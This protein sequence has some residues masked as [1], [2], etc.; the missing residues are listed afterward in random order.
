MS[1]QQYLDTRTKATLVQQLS[2]TCVINRGK[3]YL[4]CT[5]LCFTQNI[6]KTLFP[7]GDKYI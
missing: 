6:V 7:K 2:S 5:T 1:H 4:F 3:V